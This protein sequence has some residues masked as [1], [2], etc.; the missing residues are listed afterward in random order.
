[1]ASQEYGFSANNLSKLF[2]KNGLL[3]YNY[4]SYCNDATK[5]AQWMMD[6]IEKYN[7]FNQG[8]RHHYML[9]IGHHPD[10]P[11]SPKDYELFEFVKNKFNGE[12]FVSHIIDKSLEQDILLSIAFYE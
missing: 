3:I 11:L 1:M 2:L 10:Y 8:T 12:D 6:L 4:R 9:C 5:R 7:A